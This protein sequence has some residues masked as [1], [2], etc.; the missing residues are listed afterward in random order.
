MNKTIYLA[1]N[2]KCGDRLIF[3]SYE[4]V[5]V[6]M[7]AKGYY[8]ENE[9]I[10]VFYPDPTNGSVYMKDPF[11]QAIHRNLNFKPKAIK[12]LECE[13]FGKLDNPENLEIRD[14]PIPEPHQGI[15]VDLDHYDWFLVLALEID[16]DKIN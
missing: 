3:Y 10:N 5:V 11:D 1:E 16:L 8:R 9:F 12:H 2:K 14:T 6:Y 13:H 15:Y 4:E 7:T